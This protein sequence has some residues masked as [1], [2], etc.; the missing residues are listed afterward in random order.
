M[1]RIFLFL[2]VCAIISCNNEQAADSGAAAKAQVPA[3]MQGFAPGYSMSFVMDSPKNTEAVLSLWKAWKDGDLSKSRSHFAD[4]MDFFFPDGTSMIGPTDTLMQG[5]QAYRSSFKG[6]EVTID[7]AFAVT[8]T[9]KNENWVA[10][11]GS[12]I[13]TDMNGKVDT[14][15]QV[16]N[17][18]FNKD[19]KI[20]LMFQAERKGV[21][22]PPPGN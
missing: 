10:I 5:M 16:E 9:D 6:M 8:S 20:N 11:W 7:A 15:S 2:T 17:W 18:R 12:E 19:G 14:I 13:R 1:K 21:I 4:S 3:D 22:P